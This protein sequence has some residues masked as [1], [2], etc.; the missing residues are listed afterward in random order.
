MSASSLH[1][2][3]HTH[4]P[5]YTHVYVY[6]LVYI[7]VCVCLCVHMCVCIYICVYIYLCM[8]MCVYIYSCVYVYI[9]VYIDIC[10]YVCVYVCV[11]VCACV[12]VC[13]CVYGHIEKWKKKEVI[14]SWVVYK[15]CDYF[16]QTKRLGIPESSFL[17]REPPCLVFTWWREEVAHW[18]LSKCSL[19]IHPLEL[20]PPKDPFPYTV[21][22]GVRFS[23]CE[24][25]E[26]HRP[27]IYRSTTGG[28]FCS[29]WLE[30]VD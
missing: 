23:A 5:V 10:L 14:M 30:P 22:L 26:G 2:H 13:M 28:V 11:H 24:L 19:T 27:S 9:C 7:C 20:K 17:C 18:A 8:Y 3:P 25:L 29:F 4:A 15:Q 12:C 6:V 1:T 21:A 16:S